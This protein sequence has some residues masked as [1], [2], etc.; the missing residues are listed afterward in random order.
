MICFVNHRQPT[1]QDELFVDVV[2][3][4]I[5]DAVYEGYEGN[6]KHNYCI[7]NGFFLFSKHGL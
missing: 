5:V 3:V 6:D 1:I 7:E 4:I 2:E